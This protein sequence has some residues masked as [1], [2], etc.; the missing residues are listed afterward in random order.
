MCCG[1]VHVFWKRILARMYTYLN[2]EKHENTKT[3]IQ[4]LIQTSR[5]TKNGDMAKLQYPLL[6]QRGADSSIDPKQAR[7][8]VRVRSSLCSAG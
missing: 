6:K 8:T 3:I 2:M 7:P 1:I 4:T 5:E